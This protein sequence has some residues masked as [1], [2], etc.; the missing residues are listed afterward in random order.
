MDF[1]WR[2]L[3]IDVKTAAKNYGAGLVRSITESGTPCLTGMDIYVFAYLLID[4]PER[5]VIRI[6]GWES[7]GYV[8]SLPDVKPRAAGSWKNKDIPYAKLLP[9][10]I[11]MH[12]VSIPGV[13]VSEVEL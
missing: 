13:R 4:T 9:A 10:M 8:A 3:K 7:G 12:A 5:V 6:V 1:K 11:F 2:T